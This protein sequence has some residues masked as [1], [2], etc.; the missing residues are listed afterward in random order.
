MKS[1]RTV[2]AGL[3]FLFPLI[4]IAHTPDTLKSNLAGRWL[5]VK[6]TIPDKGKPVNE[7]PADQVYSF[8]FRNNGTYSVIYDDRKN[9]AVTT[10]RGKWKIVNKGK[11]LKLYDNKSVPDDPLHMIAD[12]SLPIF[13]LT[14]T[15]FV[16]KEL[17]FGMDIPGTSYYKRQ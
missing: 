1:I 11:T 3:F 14:S 10:L 15:Q 17:L 5:L 16:I 6:H 9:N 12:R 2:A 7:L 8:E 13:S 4:C